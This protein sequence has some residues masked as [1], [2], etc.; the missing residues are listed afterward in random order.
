[1]GEI[2]NGSV[3]TRCRCPIFGT[4]SPLDDNEQGF[5]VDRLTSKRDLTLM[6]F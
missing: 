5:Q 4:S 6:L 1:M 2:G 3:V